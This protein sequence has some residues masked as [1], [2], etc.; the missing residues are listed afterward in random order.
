MKSSEQKQAKK[1]LK[2]SKMQL[3]KELELLTRQALDLDREDGNGIS[4]GSG[5]TAKGMSISET[6]SDIYGKSE[7]EAEDDFKEEQSAQ[8]E[9]EKVINDLKKEADLDEMRFLARAKDAL[10]SQKPTDYIFSPPPRVQK[11]VGRDAVKTQE[12]FTESPFDDL[13]TTK[14]LFNPARPPP[15]EQVPDVASPV[16]LVP[17]APGAVP[18]TPIATKFAANKAKFKLQNQPHHAQVE[19]E[20][21]L[22]VYE[23]ESMG[24][25]SFES[26]EK[27]LSDELKDFKTFV[28]WDE[29]HGEKP[30]FSFGQ[31]DS[32]KGK[33]KIGHSLKQGLAQNQ[34]RQRNTIEN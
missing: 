20:Q 15:A 28:H 27:Q 1:S 9:F 13:Y 25:Q 32:K 6:M 8:D 3:L 10:K 24:N 29:T 22:D 5:F 31:K 33:S 17:V 4:S 2:K 23:K 16:T 19:T 26:I 30:F 34:N 14:H 11:L 18:A 7:L 21:G 12:I